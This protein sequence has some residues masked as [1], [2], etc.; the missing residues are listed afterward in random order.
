M[1]DYEAL[2]MGLVLAVTAPT[3][4]LSM[5]VVDMAESIAARLPLA[6]VER[7]KREAEQVLK[8]IHSQGEAYVY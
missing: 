4:D 8:E 6:D 3:M 7:A 2:V 1:S 5:E